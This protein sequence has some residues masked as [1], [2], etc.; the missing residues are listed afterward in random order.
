MKYFHIVILMCSL[1]F[2]NL[3]AQQVFDGGTWQ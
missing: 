2:N 1:S 3:F